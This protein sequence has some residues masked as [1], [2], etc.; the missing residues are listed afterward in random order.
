MHARIEKGQVTGLVPSWPTPS[1]G[2]PVVD[3]YGDVAEG[4]VAETFTY[5]VHADRVERRWIGRLMTAAEIV[6]VINTERDRRLR[7]GAPYAGRRI[8]VSDKGRAD[9]GGMSI[10]ALLAQSGAVPWS[11]GYALG[12]I[13]MDN[14]RVALPSPADGLTL[15]AAVGDWYGRVIQHA[16]TLKDAVLATADPLAVD[17]SEGWPD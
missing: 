2:L 9:L 3:V 17:V 12:W 15:A 10:A 16:R 7:V 6:F 8:D 4:C 13:T 1:E 11:D 14:S 5:V